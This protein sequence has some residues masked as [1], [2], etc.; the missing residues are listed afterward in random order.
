MKKKK[1]FTW[2]IVIVLLLAISITGLVFYNNPKKALKFV[3][4]DLAE[5]SLV[6]A[7][8]KNDTA[9]LKVDAILQNRSFYTLTIDTLF[10]QIK[11]AD[12]LIFTQTTALN[13]RQK[14]YQTDNVELP[15]KLPIKTIKRTIRG[16]QKQDSTQIE[17]K[18]YVVYNTILGHTKVPL[19]KVTRIK[20]PVP[21]Q[22]KLEKMD[23]KDFD[24]KKE[25]IEAVAHV[26][27]INRGQLL[28]LDVHEIHYSLVLGNNLINTKGVYASSIVIKPGSTTDLTVPVLVHINKPFKVAWKIATNNDKMPYKLKL[29]AKLDENKIYDKDDVPI[30]LEAEG[31]M[32][33]VKKKK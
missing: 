7:K 27:I 11:L 25:T 19:T 2:L 6:K 31:R 33:L 4:P 23:M 21:P 32:E 29:L 28:D 20:V 17:V 30:E 26:K 16:L 8:I 1:V 9:Y 10:Y 12:T 15:L 24:L 18:V 3:F 14:K 13:L 22:I 5:I